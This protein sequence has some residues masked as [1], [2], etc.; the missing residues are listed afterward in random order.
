[1]SSALLC[2]YKL[3]K[4]VSKTEIGLKRVLNA[5]EYVFISNNKE[6]NGI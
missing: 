3:W 4:I 6:V 1:M 2:L 5:R